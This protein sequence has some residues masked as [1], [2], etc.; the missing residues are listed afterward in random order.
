MTDYCKTL[1][2]QQ[3]V[4]VQGIKQA[5]SCLVS[6]SIAVIAGVMSWE[7]II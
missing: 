5:L 3:I 7:L 2:S 6:D 4:M 1:L